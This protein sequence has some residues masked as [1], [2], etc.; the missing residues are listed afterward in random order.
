M[1]KTTKKLWYGYQYKQGGFQTK[2]YFSDLDVQEALDSPFVVNVV[3][4]FEAANREEALKITEE[5]CNA[6]I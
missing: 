1:T 6:P 4:P 5:S 3:Y 2:P